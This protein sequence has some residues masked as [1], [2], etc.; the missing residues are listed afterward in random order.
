MSFDINK[1]RQ[2]RYSSKDEVTDRRFDLRLYEDY[3]TSEVIGQVVS[4]MKGASVSNLSTTTGDYNYRRYVEH[5]GWLGYYN[6]VLYNAG[7]RPSGY[8]AIRNN[9]GERCTQI[10][11]KGGHV[12]F[13][14]KYGCYIVPLCATHHSN[15]RV[16]DYECATDNAVLLY[17]ANAGAARATRRG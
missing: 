11:D 12:V 3:D 16:H 7:M 14:G 4:G 5:D 2:I 6:M 13:S 8:C 1:A 17:A 10:A 15:W 9:S